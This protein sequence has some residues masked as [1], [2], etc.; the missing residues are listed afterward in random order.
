MILF[1]ETNSP[2]KHR[3]YTNRHDIVWYSWAPYFL[4][5]VN[6]LKKYLTHDKIKF[7][8]LKKY[9]DYNFSY[10]LNLSKLDKGFVEHF[11]HYAYALHHFD[12]YD[13]V[14]FF[15]DLI[16]DKING[17]LFHSIFSIL[18]ALLV[19]ITQDEMGALY[20]PLTSGKKENDFPLHCDLYIP[21]ILFNVMENVSKDNSGHSIFLRIDDLFNYVLP[22][23]KKI[24]RHSIATLK[25]L[26][27]GDVR[28][29]NYDKFYGLLYHESWASTVKE[30]SAK[31][32][33]RIKL[34]KGEGYMLNDRIWMHGRDK[35]NG[36]VSTKRLHRLIYNNFKS[37][38]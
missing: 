4:K 3:T 5:E 11:K 28:E 23:T 36:G 30:V 27:K 16:N 7:I 18:R 1:Q 20:S 6:A 21:T 26:V 37:I 2:I 15:H 22:E 19:E 8:Y 25:K 34:D 14:L 35:T 10:T 31:Y 9:K 32:R 33:L 12:T 29:D 24:D 38:H 13:Q 17:K